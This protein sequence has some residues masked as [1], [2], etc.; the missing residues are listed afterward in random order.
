MNKKGEYME[1]I[2]SFTEKHTKVILL[3]IFILGIVV[4]LILAS[5]MTV[6]VYKWVDEELY[7]SMARTFHFDGNFAK[8]YQVLNYNCVIY[9]MVLSIAYFFYSASTIVFT[10]RFVGVLLMISSIFP[11]YLLSKEIWGSKFKAILIAGVSLLI[12]EFATS[13]YLVQEVLLYP[14]FLWTVYLIY[15]KFVQNSGKLVDIAII[16]LLALLFF[17]KSYAIVFAMAYFG[18]LLLIEL[19]NKNYKKLGIEIGKGLLCLGIILLGILAIKLF[20]GEGVNHYDG[21]I[22]RIFPITM[23][24]IKAFFYGIF[25]YAVFFLFCMGFLPIFIPIFKIKKYEETD[26]KF[27]LFLILSTIF[28]IIEV[29]AIVFIP[30][31]RAKIYPDKFC[32]RYLS[33]LAVPYILML[34][35]CKKEDVQINKTMILLYIISFA[36]LI[37][38]YIGQGTGTTAIDAPMLFAIQV[39][40]V[41]KLRTNF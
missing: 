17:I 34:L 41:L 20:N 25:Y 13:F 14:V 10:M 5:K 2:K 21:Q 4:Y 30:E 32:Y 9:S 7:V 22:A 26:R 12:P 19:K 33:I 11:I 6:P 28:T 15:R 40:R 23:V 39:T 18:T 29:A 35:K 31:E 8:H 16:I 27:I 37:W 3:G 1:K 38:Y 36:Y 24:E